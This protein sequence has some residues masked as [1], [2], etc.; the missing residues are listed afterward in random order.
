MLDVGAFLL[1]F[2]GLGILCVMQ[3]AMSALGATRSKTLALGVLIIAAAACADGP[4]VL[5]PGTCVAG[6]GATARPESIAETVELINSMP[7]PLTLS[8]FLRALERPLAVHATESAFSAQ[9]ARGAENPRVF[10]F[11]DPLYLAIVTDGASRD[12][13]ELSVLTSD[14]RSIKAEIV[15]P[16]TEPLRPA[17]PYEQ[18]L[19][20]EE[21]DRTFCALCHGA[22]RLV[23]SIDGPAFESSAIK[24]PP[25]LR[26]ELG[27]LRDQS[28][29]CE[30]AQ[31]NDRCDMLRSLF[32]Y[33]ATKDHDFPEAMALFF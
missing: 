26:V 8:C 22:E 24:P 30:V 15:F 6:E 2:A 12:L 17:F 7:L 28:E 23:D 27:D 20:D 21:R 25:R 4:T 13:L 14:T 29:D 10:L 9:P 11:N 31:D 5:D 1:G 33:G 3:V 19:Y 32:L 16:V 18:A